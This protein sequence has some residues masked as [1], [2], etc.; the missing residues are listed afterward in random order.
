[1]DHLD[2]LDRRTVAGQAVYTKLVLRLYDFFVLTVSNQWIWECPTT[3]LKDNYDRHLSA[4]HLDVGVGTGYFLD[5]C[6]F[7]VENSRVVLF[8]LNPNTLDY[9]RTQIAR[10]GPESYVVNVLGSITLEGLAKFD[11]V[12]INYL[13]HCLPGDSLS[14]K[15]VLFDHLRGI[16]NDGCKIFGATILN[17]DVPRNWLAQQL[18]AFYNEKGI[19]SNKNDSLGDLK[20]E[21]EKRFHEV[22]IEVVGCVALFSAIVHRD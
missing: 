16:M 22:D 6:R 5:N 10:L 1:M 17:R 11:S 14:E 12:G 7:P 9:T 13:L 8:D 18:M 21:L 19:F 15:S 20:A 4:N 3:I 2:H